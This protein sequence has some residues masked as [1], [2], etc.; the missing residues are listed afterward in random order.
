MGFFDR[1]AKPSVPLCLKCKLNKTCDTPNIPLQG[2]GNKGIFIVSESPSTGE[3]YSG[4]AL[5][6]QQGSLLRTELRKHKINV[7]TDCWF[8]YGV[9]CHSEKEITKINTKSCAA[10]LY[11]DLCKH[12]PSKIILLGDV[13]VSTFYSGRDIKKVNVPNLRGFPVWDS[14][15]NAWVFTAF[16]LIDVLSFKKDQ[17]YQNV[18]AADIKKAIEHD[19]IPLQ[20]PDLDKSI[21]RIYEYDEIAKLLE[22]VIANPPKELYFDYE[23]TGLKPFAK[24]HKVVSCAFCSDSKVAYSFCVEHPIHTKAQIRHIRELWAEVLQYPGTVKI[25]HNLNFEQTWSRKR[26]N[27]FMPPEELDDTQLITHVLDNR[28]GI[29][30]LKL[31]LF[32]HFGIHG[33]DKGSD[34]YKKAKNSNGFNKMLQMPIDK[35]LRYNAIDALGG[36]W[37]YQK[38]KKELVGSLKRAYKFFKQGMYVLAD[39]HWN[40][41]NVDEKYYEE[42]NATLLEEVGVAQKVI[43][44]S[45]ETAAFRKHTG[46]DINIGSS[47]DLRKLFFQILDYKSVKQTDSGMASVDKEILLKLNTP[48]T[49]AILTLR[50]LEKTNGTYIGGLLDECYDGSLHTYFTL[51]IARS[52]RSCIAK[53]ELVDTTNG[54]IPI[55]DVK[56]GDVVHCIDSAGKPTRQPVIW[57]GLT[58]Y[59]K[60]IRLTIQKDDGSIVE[61]K[62]TPEHRIQLEDGSYKRADSLLQTDNIMEVRWES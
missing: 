50:K 61:L 12:K 56:V 17:V 3:D 27:T 8:S 53:G 45:A 39:M 15:Y 35:L 13:A 36:M 30:G 16:S 1:V 57:A 21:R 32:I 31:Q 19:G 37:L 26:F 23:T 34:A 55:Q 49:N 10:Q 11:G 62:C 25:C 48:F 6:G 38:Q 14:T 44:N 51:N 9:R 2:E 52:Y 40:G 4:K 58:G 59:K 46:R 20:I 54:K 60:V 41:I 47:K 18:F 28:K 29:T 22:S 42:T 43:A 5:V 24:G 33:Y 7:D